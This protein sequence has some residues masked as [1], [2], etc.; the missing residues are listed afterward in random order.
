LLGAL[1]GAPAAAQQPVK[2]YRVGILSGRTL[3]IDR[4]LVDSFR[5]TMAGLGY[6]EGKNLVID[7]R[8][9]DGHFEQL[10][11]LAVELV[12]TNPDAI[13]AAGQRTTQAAKRATTSIPIV[14]TEN[15]DPVGSG[16]VASLARPGG[17]ITGTTVIGLDG[18]LL[19]L[20]REL[21]PRVRR[22]AV[23]GDASF[24]RNVGNWRGL[25]NIARP[26][27][28]QTVALGIRSHQVDVEL[29]SL[30]RLRV[31]AV[32][33]LEDAVTMSNVARIVR[34]VAAQRLPATYAQEAFA[35]AGGLLAYTASSTA[36]WSQAATYVDRILKGAKPAD[37]P[38]ERPTTFDLIVNL[39]TARQ[40]GISVPQSIL[41][42]ADQV[43]Q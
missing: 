3:A 32:I 13:V 19:Q 39:K 33:V 36:I 12:R 18:K 27:G 34:S 6:Q 41:L 8:G 9:A 26:L 17:N 24:P 16:L 2:M 37:L 7:Y 1:G 14:M 35:A 31:D 30:P 5:R 4:A 40:L 22:I 29:N 21:V 15:V 38:V 23:I 25:E 20:I 43:I 10:T 42:R 28:I 11:E